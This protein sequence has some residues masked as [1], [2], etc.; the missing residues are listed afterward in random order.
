MAARP[1]LSATG[2]IQLVGIEGVSISGTASVRFNNTGADVD[3]LLAIPGADRDVVL[4]VANGTTV[5]EGT[6]LVI[7]ALGHGGA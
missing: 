4:L 7:E 2:T 3:E 6:D 5:L 1:S